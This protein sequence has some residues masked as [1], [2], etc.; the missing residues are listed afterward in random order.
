[1]HPY[2]KALIAASLP[3]HPDIQREDL[4][5]SGEV[6]SPMNPPS[7]CTFHTRCPFVM[8]RCSEEVPLLRKW[9]RATGSHAIFTDVL[10]L[11]IE[12]AFKGGRSMTCPHAIAETGDN[13]A[14]P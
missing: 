12:L 2:T 9:N 13:A 14:L 10:S 3:T 7:G 11:A 8:D 6:P 1:M 5:L 4:V